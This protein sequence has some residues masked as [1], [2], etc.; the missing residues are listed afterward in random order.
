MTERRHEEIL[1]KLLERATHF[2]AEHAAAFYE[3]SRASTLRFARNR[4][5]QHKYH[6]DGRINLAVAVDGREAIA[7]TNQTDDDSLENLAE[8]ALALA[9]KS[10]M[11]PEFFEPVSPQVYHET[12]AWFDS[13]A[14]LNLEQRARTVGNLCGYAESHD[15]DL[16]GNLE[17]LIE[18]ITVANTS[19][20]CVSQ[21]STHVK[22][23]LTA[24]TRNGNGSAQY[25]ISEADWHALDHQKAIEKTVMTALMG[26]NPAPLEPGRYEVILSPKA[27]SEYLMFLFFAMD[28]RMAD[29]G[30]SFFA[31]ENGGSKIGAKLFQDCV[32]ISSRSDHPRL[33]VLKFGQAF[34]SGGTSAGML[35]SLGLPIRT[36]EWIT[37]GVVKNLRYSPYYAVKNG[38]DPVAY[39]FNLAMDGADNDREQLIRDVQKGVLIE[40]FWY[41][42]PTDWNRIALTGLTRDGTFL[43]E[44]G[45]ISGPVNS[46]RFNDSPVDSLNRIAGLSRPEK[47]H[48]EYLPG[49]MPWVRLSEFNLSAVS[50]AV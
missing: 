30:Q 12:S 37:E 40:S 14:D 6:D 2:G 16:F 50:H 27:I 23:S 22:L 11:N 31:A 36:T 5:T 49:L 28:A 26:R 10:P 45:R 1:N 13:T 3:T 42:N 8:G 34:G 41:V 39:P 9:K 15:V 43:I 17:T 35:F 47:V 29:S 44:N 24:R 46:F 7:E 25:Q 19:G 21:P 20:L 38:R 32:S 18:N 33:P 4:A 48:G